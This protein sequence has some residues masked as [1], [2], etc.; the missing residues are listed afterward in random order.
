EKV[1]GKSKV[2]SQKSR[3]FR[4]LLFAS[5][6]KAQPLQGIQSVV[7]LFNLACSLQPAGDFTLASPLLGVIHL[8]LICFL[9]QPR[10]SRLDFVLH[11]ELQLVFTTTTLPPE[12]RP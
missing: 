10:L 8:C 3:V 4:V 12:V 1:K 6:Q 5:S 11:R 7:T 2:K 9:F